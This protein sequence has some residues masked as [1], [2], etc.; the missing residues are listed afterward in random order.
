[1]PKNT[2][3][4]GWRVLFSRLNPFT[5]SLRA[6]SIANTILRSL[7]INSVRFSR[8]QQE[9]LDLFLYPEPRG[10]GLLDFDKY[11][12]ITQIGYE[13]TLEPLREWKQTRFHA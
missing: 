8:A 3:I 10:Y 6:P 5:K 7:E 1:M 11:K 9:Q 12:S 4:S 13:A 2:G